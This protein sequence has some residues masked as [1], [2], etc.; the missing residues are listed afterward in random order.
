MTA[1]LRVTPGE[2]RA[3]E[4]LDLMLRGR[5]VRITADV[6]LPLRP[7]IVD[8]GAQRLLMT[9]MRVLVEQGGRRE[10][11]VLKGGRR[12]RGRIWDPEVLDELKLEFTEATHGLWL[13]LCTSLES[14]SRSGLQAGGGAVRSIARVARKAVRTRA[15][16]S[17]DWLVY[18][19]FL[20][21]LDKTSISHELQ[22]EF[23]RRLAAGSPLARLFH[24]ADPNARYF[25]DNIA[26]LEPLMAPHT[27][28]MCTCLGDLLVDTWSSRVEAIWKTPDNGDFRVQCAM[29][30]R[31]LRAY[32]HLLQVHQR[33]DLAAPLMRL[34]GCLVTEVLP[35]SPDHERHRALA[36]HPPKSM[37]ERE[38]TLV[39]ASR[40]FDF[41]PKL[42]ALRDELCQERYGDPRY[43]QAQVFL[44]AAD[45]F[46]DTH[47]PRAESLRLGLRG[48][49]G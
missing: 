29:A 38:Q 8:V 15:T 13:G 17:G 35:G 43:E 7:E 16:A 40:L 32:L 24:L 5:Q 31:L 33:L 1:R 12:V 34:V 19:L 47:L 46:L 36:I 30:D 2:A 28:P 45:Q 9:S 18:T 21:N 6:P 14:F 4:I 23:R 22:H 3:L 27:L 41:V 42:S 25:P 49:L 26:R 20:L 10:Q 48:A 44:E 11:T 37:A 39:A